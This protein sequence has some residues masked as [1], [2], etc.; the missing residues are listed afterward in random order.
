MVAPPLIRLRLEVTGVVQGVGFRPLAFR[1][2]EALC[3]GGFVRNTRRGALVEV[4]GPT[5]VLNQFV[6]RLRAAPSPVRVHE[7]RQRVLESKGET[8][9]RIAESFVKGWIAPPP[10]DLAV[11]SDC[12][13]EIQNSSNRRFRYPFTA[14]A[15][16]GPRF[17][18]LESVPYDRARTTMRHF[19]LCADCLHEYENPRDRR[20]HAQ[21]TC[22]P[23]CGPQVELWGPDGQ[24]LARKDAAVRGAAQAVRDGKILA[25][26]GVG[27]FHLIVD[28]RREASVADLRRRKCREEKPFAVMVPEQFV[29]LPGEGHE[30]GRGECLVSKEEHLLL[31]SPEGPIVLL[32][33]GSVPLIAPNVAP[34]SPSLGLFFPTTPLHALLLSDLKFPVVATSGNRSDEPICVDEHEAVKRLAGIADF[35]LVHDRPI[36][37]PVED[38]VARVIDGETVLLRRARG[39]APA[40]LSLPGRGPTVLALGGHMKNTLALAQNESVVVGPHGGDLDNPTALDAFHRTVDDLPR[41]FGARVEMLAADCHPDYA[42]TRFAQARSEP[43]RYVQHH[44]AHFASCLAEHGVDGPALG[45]IW[46]GSGW[47]PDGTVWGGEFLLGGRA[48]VRRFAHFRTFPLPGGAA[49]V[50]DPRRCALGLLYE[51]WGDSVFDDALVKGWFSEKERAVFAGALKRNVACVKSSSV[52]RLFDGVSALLGVG[53]RRSFEGQAAMALEFAAQDDAASYPFSIEGNPLR[54]DW[55]PLMKTLLVDDRNGISV[56]RRAGRFH[57]TLI[58]IMVAMAKRAGEKRVALSGGCFQNR[59]L[60]TGAAR[61]LSEEGFVVLSHR[62]VPTND[63]G[64]ALGQAVVVRAGG[65]LSE[66]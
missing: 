48:A 16:C 14:C 63:G 33:Q 60:L 22:C 26:K 10:P 23:D 44:H 35:F 30:G 29:C 6:Q 28:A 58:E 40:P 52:G 11:C 32:R 25:L 3:V 64:L 57:N 38:S 49:A 36:V 24:V 51:M 12:R 19:P 45:V 31:K 41:L 7:I 56:G 54:V 20:F 13:Q 21:A 1:L 61:R 37:R 46:D 59:R 15:V 47:G 8:H 43:V 42:S 18:V 2:A 4:E 65:G 17:S 34:G 50:T 62:R 53:V 5:A 9:F 55:G 66:I 27:G 39:Y